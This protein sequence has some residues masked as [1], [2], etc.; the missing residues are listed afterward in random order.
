MQA[1]LSSVR[2]LLLVLDNQLNAAESRLSRSHIAAATSLGILRKAGL[3]VRSAFSG[4]LGI[5][6][7]PWGAAFTVAAGAVGYLVTRQDDAAKAA[8]LHTKALDTLG[9]VLKGAQNETGEL[10]RKL[11]ELDASS[12]WPHTRALASPTRWN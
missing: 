2:A 6:G 10:T 7:G 9:N 11:S 1:K 4:L 5:F 12:S 8:E 3:G